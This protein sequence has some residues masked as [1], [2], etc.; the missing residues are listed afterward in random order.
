[1]TVNATRRCIRGMT[2]QSQAAILPVEVYFTGEL[3]AVLCLPSLFDRFVLTDQPLTCISE[4]TSGCNVREL[5][6]QEASVASRCHSSPVVNHALPGTCGN[7]NCGL[8][9]VL[10]SLIIIIT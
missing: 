3:A 8:R 5:T 7:E 4:A 2:S 9:P 10:L 6:A 1:M